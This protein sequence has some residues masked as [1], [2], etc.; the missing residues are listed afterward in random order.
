MDGDFVPINQ[1]SPRYMKESNVVKYQGDNNH[2]TSVTKS[3][4]FTKLQDRRQ[5]R[6]AFLQKRMH[7][8]RMRTVR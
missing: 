4:P 2:I 1:I 7:S 3:S 6:K 5:G 8:S